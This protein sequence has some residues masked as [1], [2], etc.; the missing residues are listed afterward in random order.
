MIESTENI[1]DHLGKP[2]N[3][4]VVTTNNVITRSG[5]LV[6]GAGI[7]LDAKRRFPELPRQWADTIKLIGT[8]EYY[9]IVDKVRSLIGLQTKRHWKGP[10]PLDLLDESIRR[11]ADI[12]L[13]FQNHTIHMP[14][15]GCG[16]GGLNWITQVRPVCQRLPDNCIIY[17]HNT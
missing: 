12:A 10:S 14:R 11:L 9:I 4:I 16:M 15:P 8:S 2:N 17:G 3:W 1:W 7:A 6:M 5:E 13:F